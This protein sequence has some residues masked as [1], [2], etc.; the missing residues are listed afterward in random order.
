M[1]HTYRIIFNCPDQVGIV[2]RVGDFIAQHG[3]WISDAHHH[4]DIA[5]GCFFSR[6]V[7]NADSLDLGIDELR[8]EF[9]PIA[10]EL[11]MNWRVVDSNVPKKVVVMASKGSHCL[12][13]LFDRM[14]YQEFNCEIAAVISNHEDMRGLSEFYGYPY[15]YVPIE[16]DNKEA[17]FAEVER[18]VDQYQADTIVLARYMQIVPPALCEK[19][20]YQIINIHH[21]F[22]P[23][24]VGAKPYHQAHERG[25]KLIGAT[26]HYVTEQLDEG[27][28]I[29][30]GVQRVNHA[31]AISDLVR[32]GRDVEKTVLAKGLRAHLDDRVMVMGN[33]TIVFD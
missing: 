7:V 21:S 26:C 24:F 28:I 32:L 14:R 10:T 12:S 23:S 13:D 31:D 11:K 8:N 30:Q 4:S 3:G 15:H 25:V 17:G 6:V 1:K 33:S 5:S 2:T 20:Q 18:L 29:E 9:E 16:K 22:L 27:P 19:Y